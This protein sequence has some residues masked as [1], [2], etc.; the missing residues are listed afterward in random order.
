M[1]AEDRASPALPGDWIYRLFAWLEPVTPGFI[2]Y[3]A[4]QHVLG[5]QRCAR[6]VAFLPAHRLGIVVGALPAAFSAEVAPHLS[7]SAR[8]KLVQGVPIETL[9]EV[10]RVLFAKGNYALA[11]KFGMLMTPAYVK[12]LVVAQNDPEGMAH[13]A[14][15]YDP[16]S[17]VRV[18]QA[19][20]G[21]YLTRLAAA[22]DRNGYYKVEADLGAAL[23]VESMAGLMRGLAPVQAVRFL[24]QCAET[25]LNDVLAKLPDDKRNSILQA[26]LDLR[27]GKRQ[28]ET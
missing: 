20:S 3:W 16:P 17:L 10:T 9:I 11:A 23:P 7:D 26:L 18:A 1:S 5:P 22:L 6:V 8:V 4:A 28:P 24:A 14:Q 21:P 13:T 27:A 2:Y 15:F 19:F 25:R 12:A